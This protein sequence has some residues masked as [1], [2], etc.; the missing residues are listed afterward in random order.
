[1]KAE[2]LALSANEDLIVQV[3][4][5]GY[6]DIRTYVYDAKGTPKPTRRGVS[7]PPAVLDEL[8]TL[9]KQ[10]QKEIAAKT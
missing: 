5:K 4:A 1:M 10:A 9:L 6:V 2:T 7:I 3:N 8:L